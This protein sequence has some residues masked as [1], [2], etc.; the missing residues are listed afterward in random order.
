MSESNPASMPG[1]TPADVVDLGVRQYGLRLDA[2]ARERVALQVE[3][4]Q[5]VMAVLD[6]VEL[7]AHDEPAPEFVPDGV[8]AS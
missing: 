2:T 6:A 4:L 1:I 3:R 7:S 8:P 5:Q